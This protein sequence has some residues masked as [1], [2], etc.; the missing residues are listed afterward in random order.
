MGLIARLVKKVAAGE[1]VDASLWL[2]KLH[3]PYHESDQVLNIAYNA[4]CGGQRLDDIELRREDQTR[5]S[6]P[7]PGGLLVDL[8]Q[9]RGGSHRRTPRYR[10]MKLVTTSRLESPEQS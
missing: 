6:S 1:E 10:C 5:T 3:H 9:T 4:L 2:V 8:R 7:A